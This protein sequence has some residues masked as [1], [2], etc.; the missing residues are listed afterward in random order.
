MTLINKRTRPL[1]RISQI[2]WYVLGVIESLLLIRFFL[3]LF[4]ANSAAGFSQFI[5]QVTYAF[6]APFLTVFDTSQVA[7]S[8]FEW[9]T[10]LAMLVYWLVAWAIV[11]LL[12]MVRPVSSVEADAK[13]ERQE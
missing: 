3:K 2:V 13:L 1:Y 11:K 6:A 5:Y 4:D 12:L 8:V 7:A 9:S 10:L